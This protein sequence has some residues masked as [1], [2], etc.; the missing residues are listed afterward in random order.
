MLMIFSHSNEWDLCTPS[1][2][3]VQNQNDLLWTDTVG[4]IPLHSKTSLLAKPQSQSFDSTTSAVF[5]LTPWQHS[6]ALASSSKYLT[7]IECLH[8]L[9]GTTQSR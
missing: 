6:L 9:P 4:D 1:H 7:C 8:H 3:I 2:W 5:A